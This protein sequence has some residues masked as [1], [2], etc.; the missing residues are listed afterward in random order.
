MHATTYKTIITTLITIRE[1][2]RE[3]EREIPDISCPVSHKN[4][5]IRA[6]DKSF[7]HKEEAGS[8]LQSGHSPADRKSERW[9]L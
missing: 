9:L 2:E 1:R 8:R 6:K 5:Y 3:R 7:N 4:G